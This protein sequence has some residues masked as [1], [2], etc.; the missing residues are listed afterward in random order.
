MPMKTNKTKL[1]LFD[2]DRDLSNALLNFL[3]DAGF[4]V[5]A[6][7]DELATLRAIHEGAPQLIICEV[8]KKLRSGQTVIATA[9]RTQQGQELPIIATG[10]AQAPTGDAPLVD[11]Y[12]RKP[13]QFSGLLRVIDAL[14]V[15]GKLRRADSGSPPAVQ[16]PQL[17]VPERGKLEETPFSEIFC[18]YWKQAATGVI[19]LKSG[20][21]LRRVDFCNGFPVAARSNLVTEHLLRFLLRLGFITPDVYRSLLPKAQEQDWNPTEVLV[22]SGAISHTTLAEAEQRLVREIVLQCFK[23][24]SAAFRFSE[25]ITPAKHRDSVMLNPFDVYTT[26]LRDPASSTVLNRKTAYLST[27]ALQS[28]PAFAEHYHLLSAYT[29]LFPAGADRFDGKQSFAEAVEKRGQDDIK[30][31][32]TALVEMGTLDAVRME[33]RAKRRAAA[34]TTTGDGSR[35]FDRIRLMVEEDQGRVARAR[36]PYQV[37]GLAE[38]SGRAEVTA[39]FQRFSRFYR[40]QNFERI[41]DDELVAKARE[42]LAAF[43]NAATE[44]LGT[45]PAELPA[46]AA[47]RRTLGAESQGISPDAKVL[48]E[49]FFE[50]GSTYLKLGDVQEALTHF[51]RSTELVRDNPRYLAYEGWCTYQAGRE[52]PSK[53]AEAKQTL[54]S[55]LKLDSRNDRA[56]YFLGCLYEDAGRLDRATDCWKKAVKLNGGNHDARSALRRVGQ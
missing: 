27:R 48:A 39:R 18:M 17:R 26:W 51:A 8:D 50:D 42:L 46:S 21:T 15:D 6:A 47:D 49:V 55:V 20:S 4:A 33:G 10:A 12:L 30:S 3:R 44:V 32:L 24:T 34:A 41:G 13:Y 1:L 28:T 11:Y 36:S 31:V 25:R 53:V 14:R 29:E 52:S 2:T 7:K 9:R 35:K 16:H 38:R 37:L 45:A 23:W 54:L 22:D 43:R 56:L 5:D 40:P 19:A